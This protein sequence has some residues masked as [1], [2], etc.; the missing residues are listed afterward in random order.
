MM[1][2]GRDRLIVCCVHAS[3]FDPAAG[4]QL[5]QG[6]AEVPLAL[7]AL[8]WDR[9]QDQLFAAGVLGQDSFDRFFQGFKGKSRAPVKGQTTVVQLREYSAAVARC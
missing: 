7:I 8:E 9:G 5:E 3:A 2:T 1:V 4:G 6:P